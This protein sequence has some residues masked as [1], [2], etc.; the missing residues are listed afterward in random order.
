M[1]GGRYGVRLRELWCVDDI[2]EEY[3]GEYLHGVTA[4]LE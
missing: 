1:G 2:S 4:T 3:G